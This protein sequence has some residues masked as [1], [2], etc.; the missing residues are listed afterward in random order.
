MNNRKRT[1]L[2]AEDLRL[3]TAHTP[4]PSFIAQRPHFRITG[5]FW[6]GRADG[7]TSSSWWLA[8]LVLI[9]PSFC[10]E[11]TERSEPPIWSR[12]TRLL[13]S[14][15]RVAWRQPWRRPP[16]HAGW[17]RLPVRPCHQRAPHHKP[18]VKKVLLIFWGGLLVFFFWMETSHP[19]WHSQIFTN[20]ALK[21][22]LVQWPDGL[23]WILENT[24][25]YLFLPFV[26]HNKIPLSVFAQ[27]V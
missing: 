1:N 19:R 2:V 4:L 6:G 27:L 26:S 18:T 8:K 22:Q 14:Q 16:L 13:L 7:T 5:D 12:S 25:S 3:Q 10:Y 23:E 24:G 17:R 11:T 20:T 9:T 21:T 15:T